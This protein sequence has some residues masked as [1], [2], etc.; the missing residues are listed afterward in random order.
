MQRRSLK[1]TVPTLVGVII[2]LFGLASGVVLLNARQIFRL[3][4]VDI[5]TPKNVRVSNITDSSF[6]ISFLTAKEVRPFVKVGGDKFFISD[7]QTIRANEKSNIHYFTI[8]GLLPE[9][10]YFFTINSDGV[11]YFKDNPMTARTGKQIA[12]NTKG[13]IIY[14][15]VYSKSGE[16]LKD[17]LVYVRGGNGSLVST[18]TSGDGSFM[19]STSHIRTADLS[20]YEEFDE[21]R[22][23]IQVLIE[24]IQSTS[25]ITTNLKNSYPFP[26]IIIGQNLDL[27][28]SSANVDYTV[29]LPSV[30]G[31]FSNQTDIPFFIKNIYK[32][33]LP[34]FLNE[35]Y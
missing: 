2:L 13:G 20:S 32:E 12:S 33:K 29:P 30:F 35:Q 3:G 25:S 8:N 19:F 7:I 22:T 27:R 10:E 1:K 16:E 5:S 6:C 11:D 21:E 26:P 9:R 24:N 23:I 34:N 31:A 17:A 15:K 18:K 28:Q 14:G 4:A